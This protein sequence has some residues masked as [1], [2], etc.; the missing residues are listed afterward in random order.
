[1]GKG[2]KQRSNREVKKQKQIKVKPSAV[3]SGVA[4][5]IP[6]GFSTTKKTK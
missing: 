2:D 5:R 6:S 4:G 3:P 1:M